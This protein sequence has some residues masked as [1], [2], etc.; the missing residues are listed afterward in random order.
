MPPIPSQFVAGQRVRLPFQDEFSRLHE[1]R[2]GI[3]EHSPGP[4]RF[5]LISDVL[6]PVGSGLVTEM[7][8]PDDMRGFQLISCA[9]AVC[10]VGSADIEIMIQNLTAAVDMLTTPITIASGDFTSY[11]A[12][13]QPV[14]GP[15][16]LVLTGDRIG[17]NVLDPGADATG[18]LVSLSYA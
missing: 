1:R 15:N 14:I 4:A 9:A 8:C 16:N 18:L 5:E 13:V 2:L 7:F 12:P 17:V 6:L 10:G 11:P 3:L